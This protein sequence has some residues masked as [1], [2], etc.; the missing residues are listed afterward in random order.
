MFVFT[1]S[2][3]RNGKLYIAP[4]KLLLQ[5]LVR[6]LLA[7]RADLS[8]RTTVGATW[9]NDRKEPVTDSMP[10]VSTKRAEDCASKIWWSDEGR[11]KL[12]SCNSKCC[13]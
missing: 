5:T 7:V 2:I 4:D 3:I 9:Q 1:G 13:V 8:G 6:E 10:G 12:L 11:V